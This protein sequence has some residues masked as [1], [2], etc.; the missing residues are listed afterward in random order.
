MILYSFLSLV[1]IALGIRLPYRYIVVAMIAYAA[2]IAIVEFVPSV[3]L[4]IG[5]LIPGLV[6]LQLGYLVGVLAGSMF[7]DWRRS[8]R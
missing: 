3:P 4:S 5:A 1:G 8:R 2:A 7:R 6:A